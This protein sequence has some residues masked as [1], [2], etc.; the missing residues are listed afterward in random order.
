MVH[1]KYSLF[2]ITNPRAFTTCSHGFG[3]GSRTPT[4]YPRTLTP[5]PPTPGLRLHE[6]CSSE[7]L[8]DQNYRKRK[9]PWAFNPKNN[10][11]QL[12]QQIKVFSEIYSKLERQ[13]LMKNATKV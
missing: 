5:V 6:M 2:R 13:T 4:G 3:L 12:C 11:H 1:K 9:I 10:H 7:N 8:R